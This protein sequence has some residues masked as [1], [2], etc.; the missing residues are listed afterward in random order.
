MRGPTITMQLSEHGSNKSLFS[1][2]QTRRI[3]AHRRLREAYREALEA[4]G[5]QSP[6]FRPAETAEPA[7]TALQRIPRGDRIRGDVEED[8]LEP[9]ND[10][11]PPPRGRSAKCPSCGHEF[12]ME[13]DDDN[14]PDAADASE[15]WARRLRGELSLMEE[16]DLEN[17][18]RRLR[19]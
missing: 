19:S 13:D 12:M 6:R 14:R 16:R 1:D 18:V 11:T 2:E 4:E 3:I 5:K 9:A 7:E 10:D 15:S 8:D 17:W